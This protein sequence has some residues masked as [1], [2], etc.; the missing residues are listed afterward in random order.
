VVELDGVPTIAALG[1]SYRVNPSRAVPSPR[2]AK[3]S[4]R[5]T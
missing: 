5:K 1:K 2:A 4:E 3:M